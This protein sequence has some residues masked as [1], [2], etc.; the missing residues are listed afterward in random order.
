MERY[1]HEF[2]NPESIVNACE[3]FNNIADQI[4]LVKSNHYTTF[5]MKSSD[6][7][8]FLKVNMHFI[9]S[10]KNLDYSIHDEITTC[11]YLTRLAI[12]NIRLSK[13]KN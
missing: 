9:R 1:Y 10:L 5:K 3:A 12:W 8:Y 7:T 6:W 2:Y 11:V 13:Q 4:G